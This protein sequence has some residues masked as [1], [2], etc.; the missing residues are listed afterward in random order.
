MAPIPWRIARCP[1]AR[2]SGVTGTRARLPVWRDGLSLWAD[3]VRKT[4]GLTVVQI[5][6]ANT[7]H[8]A[9]RDN[10]AAAA[11]HY[12]LAHCEPDD[13]DRQRIR[14]KLEAWSR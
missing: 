9:G 2:M 5:Q 8:D 12:A 6:W 4:P 7:L 14:E 11:L 13:I 10:E 1:A 3:T